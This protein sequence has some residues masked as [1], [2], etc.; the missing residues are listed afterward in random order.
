M[1]THDFAEVAGPFIERAHS[2]V[3]CNVATIDSQ[4]RPRSRVLHPI[5]EGQTGWIT[6]DP[7]SLKARHLALHPYVSLAYDKDPFRPV[8][9]DCHA[10]WVEDRATLQHVWDL[11]KS[12]PEP[13]GFDPGTIYAPIGEE[14]S[15]RPKYGVIKL[16][17]YRITLYG[18][19]NPAV[20]WTPEEAG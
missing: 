18:F 19:P 1:K 8:S 3:W 11:L 10:E 5:W 20:V 4:G 2:D 9:A 17:P 14:E 12:T 16:T 6:A 15:E 13:L 7:R